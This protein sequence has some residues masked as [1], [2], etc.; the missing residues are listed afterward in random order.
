M[1]EAALAPEEMIMTERSSGARAPN[2]EE[3]EAI[4]QVR[5]DRE[6]MSSSAKFPT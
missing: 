4:T 1:A 5:Y 6:A 2:G 3:R